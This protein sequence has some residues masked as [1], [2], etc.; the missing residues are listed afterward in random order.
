MGKAGTRKIG[1]GAAVTLVQQALAD[2]EGASENDRY[3]A[4]DNVTGVYDQATWDA[5]K[6]LKRD[7]G[8]GWETM[9]DVGPGT[10]RWLDAHFGLDARKR[11]FYFKLYDIALQGLAGRTELLG[12]ASRRSRGGDRR[13]GHSA[14][15]RLDE[16]RL[17]SALPERAADDGRRRVQRSVGAGPPRRRDRGPGGAGDPP[18]ARTVPRTSPVAELYFQLYDGALQGTAGR[19]DLTVE[20]RA[21]LAGEI[22]ERAS[23]V[24]DARGTPFWGQ[25]FTSALATTSAGRYSNPDVPVEQAAQ[26]ADQARRVHVRRLAGI[27]INP[28]RDPVTH[29]LDPAELDALARLEWWEEIY[30]SV[31][32]GTA[33][34]T[35]LTLA[36]RAEL[37][38]E[39]ADASFGILI[40]AHAP[41]VD[42]RT[43]DV[44]KQHFTSALSTTAG[45]QYTSPSVPVQQAA[46]LADQASLAVQRRAR[47]VDRFTSQAT[48]AT[49]V[50][51]PAQ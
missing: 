38:G 17:E 5:V 47:E 21:E 51:A 3:L 26:L 6:R 35:D 8:L 9:G 43:D 28:Q 16:V 42:R 20:R 7:K 40:G 39:V 23:V 19:L 18:R 37:A 14:G 32:G 49:A 45:G 27:N 50:L 10:M 48:H 24:L 44:W 22:A 36:R 33:G 2:L 25:C 41:G 11:E 34:R 4:A 13:A 31:L 30:P 12:Q 1:S 46:D 29:Q 15:G